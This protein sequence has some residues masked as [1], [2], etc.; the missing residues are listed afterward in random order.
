MLKTTFNYSLKYL[1]AEEVGGHLIGLIYLF[2]YFNLKLQKQKR[3]WY[4]QTLKISY[5]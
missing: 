5:F 1:E 2:V 3:K 4:F